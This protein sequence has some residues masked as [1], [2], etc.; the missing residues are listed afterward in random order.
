MNSTALGA[1]N[2][3]KESIIFISEAHE[4]FYYEKLKEVRYQD[5]YH[6]A[7]CYCLGISDDTRRN[8]NRIYDFKTGCVKTECLH[9]G[10]QTSGSVKVAII[11]RQI[12][13]IELAIA[14]AKA[15]DG[16][17]YTIKQMEKSRKSLLT[18]LEKVAGGDTEKPMPLKAKGKEE[19]L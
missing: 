13:E 9:E 5:V 17:C 18:R 4:K 8:A 7:L 16:E 14:Q 11:E 15:D 19:T 6:K 3:K 12:D 1:E 2:T 10:W